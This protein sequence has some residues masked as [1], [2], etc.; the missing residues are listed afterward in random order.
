ML[1]HGR[2]PLRHGRSGV[3]RLAL[4]AAARWRTARG[5][6]RVSSARRLGSLGS[7]S[8]HRRRAPCS[9][10]V[11]RTSPMMRAGALSEGGSVEAAFLHAGAHASSRRPTT[12]LSSSDARR[13]RLGRAADLLHRMSPKRR[14]DPR[15]APR[16]RRR[17]GSAGTGRSSS[18]SREASAVPSCGIGAR[19][20][21]ASRRRANPP[22]RAAGGPGAFLHEVVKKTG[23]TKLRRGPTLDEQAE[24]ILMRMTRGAGPDGAARHA[25]GRTGAARCPPGTCCFRSSVAESARRGEAGGRAS[26]PR[27]PTNRGHEVVTKRVRVKILPALRERNLRGRRHNRRRHGRLRDATWTIA[28]GCPGK[29]FGHGSP[30]AGC[31]PS[32]AGASR[33]CCARG[34]LN[35]SDSPPRAIISESA[36]LS[37]RPMR[38]GRGD[39]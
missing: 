3:S 32:S 35:R 17:K 28:T 16:A 9:L 23:A 12:S 19:V 18:G 21:R 10:S 31:P 14:R 34:G 5:R 30:R 4:H 22:A 1:A 2:G 25:R 26:R 39:H 13:R 24:T 11:A 37:A 27:R 8:A 15:R 7:C 29:A 6:D 20:A 36:L 33:K 38:H